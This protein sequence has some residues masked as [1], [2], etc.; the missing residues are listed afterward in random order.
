M[1][2]DNPTG[3]DNQQGSR[4]YPALDD[5]LTP[6]RL[7][8]ELLDTGAK[9]LE[10][11]LQGA[12]RDGTRSARHHTHRIGQSDPRWLSLLQH[13]LDVLGHR[14][15]I[16]REGRDRQL[17]VL[18]TTASFLSLEYDATPLVG[19]EHGIPYVRGCFDA[20]GGM[21]R[22]PASRL[23]LQLCQKDHRSLEIVSEILS[24]VGI[25]C[26][27]IHNPSRVVDPEYWRFYVL[28]RSHER[29]VRLVGVLASKKAPADRYQDE[30]IVHASWR[31]GEPREQ[32]SRTGR[33]GWI[34]SFLRSAPRSPSRGTPSHA[35]PAHGLVAPESITGYSVGTSATAQYLPG[36]DPGLPERRSG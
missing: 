13:A 15:W 5:P 18:E 29:F 21:P 6:Q 8:A 22:D 30:D 2:S 17:W 25:S 36:P 1:I 7:H 34:T 9:G 12:L 4:G 33:C 11:Y 27:R 20:E 28:A 26:G 19:S 24:S 31:H 35:R 32:G 23:Y 10:A 14:S 16:Y 3:A